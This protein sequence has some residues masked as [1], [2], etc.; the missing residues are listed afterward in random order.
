MFM[1]FTLLRA[2]KNILNLNP[3]SSF[4]TW[5]KEERVH[6]KVVCS[7]FLKNKKNKQD[8]IGTFSLR[9]YKED[10]VYAEL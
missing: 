8:P 4:F 9:P 10:P 7:L 2:V 1:F 6:V 5:G 3:S